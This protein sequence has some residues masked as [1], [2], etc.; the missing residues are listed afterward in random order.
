MMIPDEVQTPKFLDGA[1][2]NVAGDLLRCKVTDHCHYG[3]TRGLD[4]LGG[5]FQRLLVD[6]DEQ[7]VRSLPCEEPRAGLAHSRG[8]GRDYTCLIFKP[9]HLSCLPLPVRA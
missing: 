2:D 3:A 9:I 7:K 8:R 6:V 1:G 4:L 5:S